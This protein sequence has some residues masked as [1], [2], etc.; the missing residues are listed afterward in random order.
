MTIEE[1]RAT[2]KHVDSVGEAAQGTSG[3][4]YCDGT[5]YVCDPLPNGNYWT[6]LGNSQP[7]GTLEDCEK[8]LYEWA[9]SNGYGN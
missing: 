6:V 2:R 7:E 3:Y 4:V 8:K 5:L 1:F 9:L